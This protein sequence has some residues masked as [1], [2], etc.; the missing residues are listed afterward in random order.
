[1][2]LRVVPNSLNLSRTGIIT[3]KKVGNAVTR[4]RTK[5]LLREAV[6]LTPV[7]PGWDIVIVARRKMVGKNFQDVQPAFVQLLERSGL[8]RRV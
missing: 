3:S 8:L 6:R 4:N 2:V 7:E 1:M 5:R